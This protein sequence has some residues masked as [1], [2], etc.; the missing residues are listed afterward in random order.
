MNS[1]RFPALI[2]R[3]GGAL[4]FAT[5]SFAQTPTTDPLTLAKYDTNKNG[6]LD[7]E[8]VAAM[9]AARGTPAVIDNKSADQ[10]VILSPFE[11]VSQDRGYYASSTMS[12]TR[13]NSKV[14]DLASSI[15][16]ITKEQMSDFAML[17]IN[18][19]F[20]YE[21][22]TEGTGTYTQFEVDRNGSP[23]DNSLNPQGSN[24]VRGVGAAN[25]S[26][27]NFETSGRM[28]IDPSVL[29]AV[30]ISRG[31]N[32]TVFGLGAA[33]GTVNMAPASA[34]LTR[35]RSQTSM[36]WDSFDGYRASL[37]INRVLWRNKL[38]VRGNAVF[39]HDGYVRKPS[40]TDTRRF[41][42]MIR[43]QP[44]K[45]TTLTAS[46]FYFHITGNRPNTTPPRDAITGW[47]KAGM[48]TWDPVTT[49]AKINGARVPG[50]FT[51]STLPVYFTSASIRDQSAL[52]INTD[53]AIGYWGP[54]RTSSTATPEGRNQNIVFVNTTPEQIRATQPLFSSDPSVTSKSIYDW[55]HV[56]LAAM[57][58]I[59]ETTLMTHLQ[60]EQIFLE[61]RRH[62]LALQAGYFRE[63]IAEGLKADVVIE[64]VGISKAFELGLDLTAPGGTLVTVGLPAANDL[65]TISP[66]AL[67]SQ[68]KKIVG[69]YLGSAVAARDI[70]KFADLWRSGLLPVESL[71]SSTITLE[72][73]NLGMDRLEK[74]DE[75]RQM[76]T[77]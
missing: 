77:F 6:R 59:N 57:N 4:L 44:F 39:Q 52:F 17:D 64:A 42:T 13:L 68:G 22:G 12:G 45:R 26:F 2:A 20:L 19:I 56:N 38:A 23:T 35:D 75:L 49:T 71:V 18:D 72:E 30:E 24:R 9:Q 54:G 34:N 25:L 14:E 27:A 73:I 7:P 33:A 5:V 60:I 51:A 43:Y 65:A 46:H 61:T 1:I 74:G 8:E 3:A 53:G 50:T 62:L 76:I 58:R 47:I 21:A 55:E 10:P 66:L 11:V 16:V 36:R 40:G 15:S 67:V 32:S 29:D 63:A 31:P 69:S 48:P 28:P 37:D 41:N 70:P